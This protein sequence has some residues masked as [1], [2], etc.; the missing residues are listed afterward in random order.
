[1]GIA[2]YHAG[3]EYPL[4]GMCQSGGVVYYS[5]SNG[6]IGNAVS[7]TTKWR[8]PNNEGTFMDYA[9]VVSDPN[10][11]SLSNTGASAISAST[12]GGE[13]SFKAS[14]TNTGNVLIRIAG[15]PSKPAKTPT[16]ADL[17][18][19]FIRTDVDTKF[20]DMGAY[21]EVRREVEQGED[22]IGKWFKYENGRMENYILSVSIAP[23]QVIT[24][25]YS[26]TFV[27]ITHIGVTGATS[28]YLGAGRVEAIYHTQL[29]PDR[30]SSLDVYN[31]AAPPSTAVGRARIEIIGT[32]Y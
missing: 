22:A 10:N 27:A 31:I 19:G 2:E 8:N 28:G 9:Q 23:L 11:I 7:D 15:Q 18:A 17:P 26:F 6:N 1:M 24:I 25:N 21:Y 13:Y 12:R 16:G 5:L 4:N 3:Q 14:E 29:M 32:W 30:L 20:R